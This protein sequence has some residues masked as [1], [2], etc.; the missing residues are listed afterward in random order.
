M[1]FIYIYIRQAKNKQKQL[2]EY[3]ICLRSIGI[4]KQG[5][6]RC[7]N[8]D[9]FKNIENSI[10]DSSVFVSFKYLKLDT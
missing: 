1:S 6:R 4:Q 8:K 9:F 10:G 7:Q 5:T 3:F 2:H